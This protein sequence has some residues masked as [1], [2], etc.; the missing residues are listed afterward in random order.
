[1][2]QTY[3]SVTEPMP[4]AN[5]GINKSRLRVYDTTSIPTYYLENNSEFQIEL[6]NPT[7]N[8]VLA[9]ISID[10]V[11]ISQSGLV[12]RPAERI[13]LD[14][15][16]DIAKKFKFETYEVSNTIE[17]KAA[18]AKNGGIKIEFYN[19]SIP[20]SVP[21]QD[22]Y[23]TK[24]FYDLNNQR[25]THIDYLNPSFTTSTTKGFGFNGVSS[26]YNANSININNSIGNVTTSSS[27]LSDDMLTNKATLKSKSSIETGR[28]EMGGNSK[29]LFQT[30]SK[31]FCYLPFFTIQL[32]VLP[33]SQKVT[34]SEDLVRTY[35]T[36]C[37]TKQKSTYKFCPSCGAKA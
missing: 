37:G 11:A 14:R 33:I 24:T 4:S 27:Y 5:L 13:W 1:M 3:Q 29:Q 31:T 28:V 15:Y 6:F 19:E 32:K 9:K 23:R 35:C 22:Y 30:S 10:G 36:N 12:L 2:T 7:S 34:T 26:C 21:V 18:I 25:G 17:S 20:M 16:L 8:A